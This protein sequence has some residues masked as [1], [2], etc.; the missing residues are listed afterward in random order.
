MHGK[1]RL[2]KGEL[3]SEKYTYC[4]T[5]LEFVWSQLGKATAQFDIV[6]SRGAEAAGSDDPRDGGIASAA[7]DAAA[8]QVAW[9]S[10]VDS[11]RTTN[12]SGGA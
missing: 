9:H 1:L 11:S 12:A 3:N 8:S 10:T 5:L 4:T 6:A 2:R 7:S